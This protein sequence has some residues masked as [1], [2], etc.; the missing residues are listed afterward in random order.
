MRLIVF[1]TM[2]ILF[3]P[4]VAQKTDTIKKYLDK[5]LILTNK[6][7]AFYVAIAFPQGDHWVLR[8]TYADKAPIIESYFTDKK[9][10]I[11]DGSFS[12]F[13]SGG[14]LALQGHFTNNQRTG[15]WKSWHKNGQLKDSG[16]IK[17]DKLTG[18]WTTWYEN[19]TPMTTAQFAEEAGLVAT[20]IMPKSLLQFPPAVAIKNGAWQTW[21]SSGQQKDSGYYRDNFKFGFWRTWY[22]NGKPE[23]EGSYAADEHLEGNWTFYRE[24]GSISTKEKYEE[25]KLKD[26]QCFDEKGKATGSF[27][28]IAKPPVLLGTPY[29]WKL[30]FDTHLQ[31]SKES[32]KNSMGG[33][34]T[35]RF[36]IGKDGKL[37]NHTLLNS[38]DEMVSADIE[39]VVSLM[40]NWSPAILHNRPFE[41]S[42]D[43]VVQFFP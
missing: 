2:I 37:S 17:N 15:V 3:K 25:N 18:T 39:K 7:G 23:S 6:A 40:T 30:F 28:S 36:V 11:R 26:L 43:Y 1:I 21:S 9:L 35:I 10:T 20:T 31:W 24:D 33:T 14:V 38:P 34:I 41:Y 19:G 8:S 42:F 13:Y 27:C 16:T 32:V 29:D 22:E 4:C 12:A 5:N